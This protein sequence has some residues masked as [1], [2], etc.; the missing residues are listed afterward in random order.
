[1]N[2]PYLSATAAEP[3][4][5]PAKWAWLLGSIAAQR[6]G[7]K[8]LL[9]S[10]VAY[11]AGAA[12]WILAARSGL[13]PMKHAWLLAIYFVSSQVC[14][15]A[16]LRSGYAIAHQDPT[17]AYPQVLFGVTAVVLTYCLAD[18]ARGAALQMLCV[19]LVFDMQRLDARRIRNVS[20][21]AVV[22]LAGALAAMHGLEMDGLDLKQELINIVMAAVM[23]P[24]LSL[25]AREVGGI[26]LRQ[27]AQKAEL[28][29]LVAQLHQLS[30]HD[31]LTGL[32]NR[33]CMTDL[34]QEEL[35]RYRRSGQPFCVAILDIDWF[36]SI[37]DQYGHA[38]G[39]TVLKVF[40]STARR[41]A[42]GSDALARWGGEEFL[43]LMPGVDIDGGLQAMARMRDRMLMVDWSA[44]A[45][46]LRVGFSAGVA[47]C[48]AGE[49]MD[50]LLERADHALYA[51][52]EGGRDRAEAA[53][54]LP[55]RASA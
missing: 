41:S 24:M 2:Q 45:G 6:S 31:A 46:G 51:A 18:F 29:D 25:I 19:L 42:R 27:V 28:S 38:V 54:A 21:C 53:P 16:L 39:D 9:W 44:H 14:F 35:K 26:R 10:G 43:L 40:A 36:K 52:K 17:L 13:M 48:E 34:L 32:Y 20:V 49:T 8:R 11:L 37:N 55:H 1:M 5:A 23:L 15:Y 7:V 50:S 33:R 47:E 4:A 3:A 30:T 12:F 22:L